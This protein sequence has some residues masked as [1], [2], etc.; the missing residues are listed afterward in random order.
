MQTRQNRR[1]IVLWCTKASNPHIF[2]IVIVYVLACN[3]IKL[4]VL[5]LGGGG[6]NG[7]AHRFAISMAIFTFLTMH[8]ALKMLHMPPLTPG[9]WIHAGMSISKNVTTFS[10]Y[11]K[12]ILLQIDFRMGCKTALTS[13]LRFHAH[14][15]FNHEFWWCDHTNIDFK[16]LCR[17]H[18]KA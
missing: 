2:R 1:S 15:N 12:W 6:W 16:T 10:L 5:M 13:L 8:S 17:N 9:T 7:F 18:L 4:P 14:M 3:A 11:F